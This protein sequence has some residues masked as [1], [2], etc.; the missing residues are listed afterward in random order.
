[1]SKFLLISPT[2]LKNEYM[3]DQNLDEGYVIP[4]IVK[5]QDL[6]VKP[7]L[8]KT[9]YNEIIEQF[10]NDTLT[11]ENNT[12]IEEYIQTII[13]WYVCAEVVYATAYKLK[14]EG[15]ESTDKFNE[16]VKISNH[17]RKDSDAYQEVLKLYVCQNSIPI[18]PEKNTSSCPIYLGNAI[19]INY[20]N[21]PDKKK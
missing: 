4:L 11:D 19:G 16:L 9:L 15:I 18:V 14:N 2:T 21:Q 5:C 10:D 20:H 3:I 1:M 12:L 13:G 8:G 6:I 17:Y 7:L